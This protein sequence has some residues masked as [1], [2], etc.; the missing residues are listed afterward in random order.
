MYSNPLSALAVD[1][2]RLSTSLHDAVR[3]LY[4][5]DSSLIVERAQE[6]SV[7]FHIGRHLAAE[8]DQWTDR[9]KVDME[10]NRAQGEET[11]ERVRKYLPKTAGRSEGA[12][13]PDLIV[14]DRGRSAPDANL[15]VMEV[16]HATA[17]RRIDY[18]KL[19]GFREVLGYRI[20]VYLELR[21]FP[22]APRWA[23][24]DTLDSPRMSSPDP[25]L[26]PPL[27]W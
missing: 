2:D 13:R 8:L 26:E 27:M 19:R 14:H 23:W 6:Q 24:Y 18:G 21:A 9:W 16:K 15:L 1:G 3:R 4:E 22:Q 10:Y 11:L 5:R 20:S 25:A 17:D 12:V 7:V